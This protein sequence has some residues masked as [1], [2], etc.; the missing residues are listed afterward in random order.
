M[1]DLV[2]N[3]MLPLASGLVP[4]T[5]P[6][7]GTVVVISF[8]VL[9]WITLGILAR[10][11]AADE[12]FQPATLRSI[13]ARIVGPRTAWLVDAVIAATCFTS[14]VA[15]L[16][17]ASDLLCPTVDEILGTYSSGRSI[18]IVALAATLCPLCLL[19]DVSALAPF[20]LLGVA[21]CVYVILF[22]MCRSLDGTY[23][24]GGRYNTLSPGIVD[25]NILRI[26]YDSNG[27]AKLSNDRHVFSPFEI[28]SDGSTLNL[29]G[30][31]SVGFL[32]HY[33][34]A[35]YY[36]SLRQR[37]PATFRVA[38]S[39]AFAFTAGIYIISMWTGSAT[40]GND[41]SPTILNNYSPGD[42]FAAAG[43]LGIGV[44]LLTSFPLMFN[45]LT[46]SMTSLAVA[47]AGT[48]LSMGGGLNQLAAIVF[49]TAVCLSSLAYPDV[50]V[51]V[52]WIGAVFGTGKYFTSPVDSVNISGPSA[53]KALTLHH[54]AFIPTSAVIYGFPGTM[55]IVDSL[56]R[57][58][59]DEVG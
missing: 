46:R 5:S 11:L 13:W 59:P 3:G 32:S 8:A 49:L 23:L 29:L 56:A 26:G 12:G 14:C 15:Y 21:S 38:S 45:G 19:K 44:S 27:A 54:L 37:S 57:R 35:E 47:A 33:N 39:G 2:P 6:L 9:S 4:G 17:F 24:S 48:K 58:I 42:P 43:R 16:D 7:V 20:S 52:E 40:F 31:I 30:M 22:M 10:L 51:I 36:Y 18:C 50:D 41:C 28:R 55:L 34:A 53:P 1:N 25:V